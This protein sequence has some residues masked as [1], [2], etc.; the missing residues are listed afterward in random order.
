[1]REAG[2]LLLVMNVFVTVRPVANLDATRTCRTD[3]A[4][5]IAEI[6]RD[7]HAAPDR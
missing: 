1:M 3:G 5:E 7:L 2:A 6:S 4:N